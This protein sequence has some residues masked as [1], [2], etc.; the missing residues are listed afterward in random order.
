MQTAP[1]SGADEASARARRRW[2]VLSTQRPRGAGASSFASHGAVPL[3][4]QAS[5]DTG[6]RRG[7]DARG[8]PPDADPAREREKRRQEGVMRSE[9]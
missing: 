7:G 6:S 8:L 4:T 9:L 2:G 1:R 5:L 3:S